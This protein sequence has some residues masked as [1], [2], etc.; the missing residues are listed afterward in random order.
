MYNTANYQDVPEST[1]ESI[2]AYC[3]TGRPTGDFLRRVINNDLRGAFIYA[4]E[5]NAPV[6]KRIMMFLHNECPGG[7]HGFPTAF[8]D[9]RNYLYER[10]CE[11]GSDY[12]S[13]NED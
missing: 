7:A 4:D 3:K 6:M 2:I 11:D 10:L 12:E 13:T 5:H 1:L 8:D 9:W